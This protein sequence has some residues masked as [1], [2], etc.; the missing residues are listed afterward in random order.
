MT[1]E[2]KR[3][4]IVEIIDFIDN[5]TLHLEYEDYLEIM[6][7]LQRRDTDFNE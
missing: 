3:E 4:I 6:E 5:I 7:A 2:E 1:E